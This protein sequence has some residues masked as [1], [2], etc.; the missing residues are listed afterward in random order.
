VQRP[1]VEGIVAS[2]E[3]FII[4]FG[5]V[6][7]RYLRGELHA[8]DQKS[9]ETFI[10]KHFSFV[11]PFTPFN[12]LLL[13]M[14]VFLENT[15]A[16]Q[17]LVGDKSLN[18]DLMT[19]A[20]RNSLHLAA[21]NGNCEIIHLL[22]KAGADPFVL[23][24]DEEGL[25]ALHIVCMK[26]K[27]NLVDEILSFI[28][29]P[30]FVGVQSG[31]LF[32]ENALLQRPIPKRDKENMPRN[33]NF[34]ATVKE[35]ERCQT[36]MDLGAPARS[37]MQLSNGRV[38][39]SN[40]RQPSRL[41][42]LLDL[43]SGLGF[44]AL[45]MAARGDFPSVCEVLLRFGANETLKTVEIP[46]YTPFLE[47][48]S[49]DSVHV[50]SL[51]IQRRK[52]ANP[53]TFIDFLNANVG[54][55]SALSIA[56]NNCSVSV[57][58]LLLEHGSKIEPSDLL[59]S[60][61]EANDSLGL[62]ALHLACS[63]ELSAVVEALLAYNNM[64]LE[65]EE[66]LSYIN[67][68]D[69]KKESALD[70]ALVKDNLDIANILV[71]YG[72]FVNSEYIHLAVSRRSV[73]WV[74]LFIEGRNIASDLRDKK[75]NTL[76]I[77][78]VS[79]PFMPDLEILRILL[80]SPCLSS[81][82][83]RDSKGYTAL[84]HTFMNSNLAGCIA[85]MRAGA[86]VNGIFLDDQDG[87]LTSLQV[88]AKYSDVEILEELLRYLSQS[89]FNQNDGYDYQNEFLNR[90]S[91]KSK[92][93]ALSLATK[94]GDFQRVMLLNSYGS[95]VDEKSFLF[96]IRSGQ[97]DIVRQ[98]SE[99]DAYYEGIENLNK[100]PQKVLFEIS[101]N[102]QTFMSY[103]ESDGEISDDFSLAVMALGYQT[104]FN[105][106]AIFDQMKSMS[107]LLKETM[108]QNFDEAFYAQMRASFK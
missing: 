58:N 69:H 47:A 94:R 101:R 11:T 30:K 45:H 34:D 19:I 74:R 20:G 13:F 96:A 9:L 102:L 107:L 71:N 41:Q 7:S 106:S 16:V 10:F 67:K 104:N 39:V 12:Q 23:T 86:D 89:R 27:S 43:S 28:E 29:Q 18:V 51:L 46:F 92:E 73:D 54:W 66:H 35:D 36:E 78:A 63:M 56:F 32:A 99:M 87:Q 25:S 57:V 84:H 26:D 49:C 65:A 17:G 85:L 4:N 50:A 103:Q 83:A 100:E 90:E 59:F 8:S 42:G 60:V 24:N 2:K 80:R 64:S 82:E 5:E 77:N 55:D 3:V 95:L 44:T 105:L 52:E 40:S 38:E 14:A 79:G 75:G 68:V 61:S 31:V 6:V 76:L 72:A 62:S 91:T 81:I 48:C 70:K 22:L 108:K 98:F 93:T 15:N 37:L 53:E 21:F 33:A 1:W 88:V 97:L